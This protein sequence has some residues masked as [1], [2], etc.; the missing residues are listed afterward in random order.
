M[1][2]VKEEKR[3]GHFEYKIQVSLTDFGWFIQDCHFECA[4]NRYL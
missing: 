2:L 4:K 1:K 3:E